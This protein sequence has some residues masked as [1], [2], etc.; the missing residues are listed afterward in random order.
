M[1]TVKLVFT[2]ILCSLLFAFTANAQELDKWADNHVDAS[3]AL[4]AWVKN[5]PD[6]A[7]YIFEWDGN[8]PDRSQ[9]MVTWAITHPN[10]NL[11]KFSEDHKDWT[12]LDAIVTTH[13]NGADAFVKICRAFHDA[14]R[15]LMLHSS[16]L[17]WAG[18]HLYKADA[19]MTK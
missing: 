18:D 10:E 3:K 5:F 2:G 8:H 7:H 9:A 19:N 1:K 16:A 17:K 6:A 4:G 12:E 14:F 11:N 15:D 13:R